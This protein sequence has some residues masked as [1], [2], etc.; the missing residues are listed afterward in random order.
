MS[1]ARRIVVIA[2]LAVAAVGCSRDV[3]G[4]A[5]AVDPQAVPTG[6]V[7]TSDPSVV[8][9]AVSPSTQSAVSATTSP[10]PVAAVPDEFAGAQP[11]SYYF[12]S[13]SGKFECAILVQDESVVGCHGEI[14]AGAPR[15]PGSGAPDTMVAPNSIRVAGDAAASFASIGDPQFHRFDGAA[16]VLAYGQVLAVNGF[17]C[18]VDEQAGVTCESPAEHGFTVSD[19]AYELW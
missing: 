18:S 5:A 7:V 3:E 4:T 13:P 6:S 19:A 15:V 16:T 12:T 11:R 2:A 10:T 1:A 8:T 14:P 17:T 9:E